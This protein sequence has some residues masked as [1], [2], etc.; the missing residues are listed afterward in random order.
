MTKI[1]FNGI[2]KYIIEYNLKSYLFT[3]VNDRNKY[4]TI[5]V[6]GK[7]NKCITIIVENNIKNIFATIQDINYNK[8][9]ILDYKNK[10]HI[11][12]KNRD[13]VDLI[14]CSIT[15]TYNIFK[16][17]KFF[18]L[19]D[20]TTITCK[21]NEKIYLSDFY[22]CKYGK[23]WYEKNFNALP[24]NIDTVNKIKKNIDIELSH[25]LEITSNKFF[26]NY[27][28][29]INGSNNLRNNYVKNMS[30]KSFLHK[31]FNRDCIYYYKLFKNFIKN[32]LYGTDWII[33]INNI[34]INKEPNIY[35]LN[36]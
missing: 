32:T 10:K 5:Y 29:N 17:I 9:C 20:N 33:D 3:I 25:P 21:N 30:L 2:N 24:F 7:N 22:Y 36:E 16:H 13:M 12:E 35:T 31:I 1:K 8:K 19:T 34:K 11:F 26:K 14:K 6:G 18:T 15:L 23:T 27:Y 28:K 4:Y